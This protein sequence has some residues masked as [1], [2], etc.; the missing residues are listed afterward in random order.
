MKTQEKKMIIIIIIAGLIIL[1]GILIFR[2]INNKETELEIKSEKNIIQEDQSVENN[3]E[4]QNTF[5]IPNEFTE[6]SSDGTRLNVS[7]KIKETKNVD[8]LEIKITQLTEKD[9]VT[10]LLGTVTNKTNE[11][12]G[13]CYIKIIA[14]DQSGNQIAEIGGYIGETKP[15][16]TSQ[17]NCSATLDC[18]NAY[19]IE[20]S[21]K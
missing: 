13:E 15:G 9:N 10:K 8:G 5:V 12:K 14:K 21:K 2:N 11:V 20:I 7:N 19:D 17:L 1:G 3:N 16:E 4:N 18:V 6:I